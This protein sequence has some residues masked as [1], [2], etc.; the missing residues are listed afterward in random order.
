[1]L[2]NE[3]R[4]T[5]MAKWTEYALEDLLSYEQPTPYIVESTDYS[6]NYKKNLHYLIIN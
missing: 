4:G 5:S 2:K 6:D 1:M 3:S